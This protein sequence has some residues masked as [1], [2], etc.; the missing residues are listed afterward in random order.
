MSGIL[1]VYNL[2][3]AP[4]EGERLRKALERMSSRAVDGAELWIDGAAALGCAL[5]RVAPESAAENQPARSADTICVLDGRIDNREELLAALKE[6]PACGPK[7]PDSDLVLAAYDFYGDDLPSRLEGDFALAIFDRRRRRLI[8][9]RDRIGVRPLCWARF[10]KSFVF[11]SDAKAILAMIDCK[12]APDEEMLAEFV[13]YFPS[14]EAK[15]RTFFKAVASLPPAHLAIAADG[16]VEVR[17][18]FEFD[19]RREVRLRGFDEYAEAFGDLF[20]RS[21]RR[22]LRSGHPIAVSVSGGLDSSYIFCVAD[23][24]AGLRPGIFGLNHRGFSGTSSDEAKYV[25]ELERW[26]RCPIEKLDPAP[27]FIE[28]ASDYAWHSESPDIEG[29]GTMHHRLMRR[30]RE[31][32]ARLLLTGHW[33]DQLLVSWDYLFDLLRRGR[34]MLFARHYRA[35]KLPPAMFARSLA[36][37]LVDSWMPRWCGA[38]ARRIRANREGPWQ[39]SWFTPRF[40]ELLRDRFTAP[41]LA[42]LGGSSHA[43]A[44]YLQCR[45]SYQ[46]HCMEWNSRVSGSAGLEMAF[47]FLDADVVQFLM[48]IPGEMQARDGIARNL[49]RK[50][51]RGIAPDAIVDRRDKGIFTNIGN[52]SVERD[53]A[54]VRKLLG[55]GSLAVEMGFVDGP[56]LWSL[57]DRWREENR[58]SDESVYAWRILDL[59]GMEVFLR[60]FFG[61]A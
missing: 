39:A 47:P 45:L 48:G 32:G 9:A 25:E 24:E 17:R 19:T 42:R 22:R 7:S 4:V 56:V 38:I 5:S 34:W 33:G 29:M 51:M 40:R 23:R 52:E 30:A 61:G 20:R 13:L 27:G 54:E 6:H 57:L 3:G 31:R 21:M 36:R 46:V 60:R 37:E 58:R 10:A 49:M 50:A 18:Y 12:L 11:A 35:W 26:C 55:P 14:S 59:C 15:Q 16:R 44:A 2:D 28:T 43:W 53:F 1:G 41:R 8:V